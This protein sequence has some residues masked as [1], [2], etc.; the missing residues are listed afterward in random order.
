[1]ATFALFYNRFDVAQIVAEVS[2]PG[3][4]AQE[5]NT[6]NRYWNGGIKDWAAAPQAPQ[7][8]PYSCVTMPNDPT[9]QVEPW[10]TITNNGNGTWTVCD[11][12]M[13]IIIVSGTQV[14]KQGLIDFLRLIGT[15]YPAASY[16]LGIADD[17]QLNAVEPW[18][19]V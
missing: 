6:A 17:V 12:Q 3:L 18:P 19:P 11:P 4:T 10:K 5:R 2:N 7:V 13:T 8:E 16:M 14:S 9:G 1:M 15:K